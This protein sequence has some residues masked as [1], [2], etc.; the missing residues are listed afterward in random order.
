MLIN[1]AGSLIM[2]EF[3]YNKIRWNPP[4]EC[5]YLNLINVISRLFHT[6]KLFLLKSDGCK[7]CF[8]RIS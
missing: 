3:A 4:D 2:E 1:N 6:V 5:N 7:L 8:F